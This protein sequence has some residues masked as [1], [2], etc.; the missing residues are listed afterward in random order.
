FDWALHPHV[1][2]LVA[3]NALVG[4]DTDNQPALV[5]QRLRDGGRVRKD[6][7]APAYINPGAAGHDM[8]CDGGFIHV[9]RKE[10]T[11]LEA[12]TGSPPCVPRLTVFAEEQRPK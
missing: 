2:Q 3:V 7:M 11:V 1:H 4:I 6:A 12:A 10:I 8:L 5:D 9:S